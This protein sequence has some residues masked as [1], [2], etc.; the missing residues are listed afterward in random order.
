MYE[1]EYLPDDAIEYFDVCD[2]SI[3]ETSSMS[4]NERD[5]KKRHELYKRSDPGYYSF[6][7]IAFNENG[8]KY[9]KKTEVYE[10]PLSGKIRNAP[11]GIRENDMV[12][13]K[14][15]D[16]YFRIKDCGLYPGSELRRDRGKL[17]YLNPEE[18]E[19][20][21]NITIDRNT[22]EAWYNK[23]LTMK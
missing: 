7:I 19:R 22:K 5:R 11:T 3:D 10:S 2:V 4:T 18:A 14:A 17:F 12:G 20:H 16:R 8:E 21:L 6:K 9:N 13:S 15:E 1:E 23:Q